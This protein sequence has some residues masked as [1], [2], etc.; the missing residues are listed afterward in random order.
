MSEPSCI[1]E[2]CRVYPLDAAGSRADRICVRDGRIV[3]EISE[4][5]RRTDLGGRTVVPGLTDSHNHLVH[6]GVSVTRAVDLTG[7][8]SVAELQNRLREFRK[9]NPEAPWLLGRR[10]DQEL[11]AEHRWPNRSDLDAVSARVPIMVT[12]LCLHAAVA[13]TAALESVRGELSAEQFETGI[14]TEDAAEA[15]W[16]QIPRPT[17]SELETAA[18]WALGE[19]RKAGLAG[20]HCIVHG[21]DELAV[22][23]KLADAGRLPVRVQVLCPAEWL[24]SLASQGIVTGS[25][26]EWLRVG[27]LK[28]YLDGSMGARTAALKE[29]FSDN[30]STSG[31]LFV[32]ERE[33]A[34]ALVA[35]QR[36]GF[37]AAIHAIG[38]AA[39]ECALEGI[40]L[41]MPDGNRANRLRHR[42]EHAA[43]MNPKLIAKMAALN[44]VASVQPQFITTDFWTWQRV[45]LDRYRWTYPF[46]SMLEA[47][48]VLAMG[49]DC[50][51]ERLHPVELLDRAVNREPRSLHERLNVEQALRAYAHGSAFAGFEENARGSLETGKLADFAVLSE[52]PFH[53]D[54]ACLGELRIEQ[55]VVGGEMQ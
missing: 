41:A 20:V 48:V 11:F 18:V 34:E 8:R 55:N 46:R 7:C 40:E 9:L 38:D 17:E 37:Q 22:L 24:D 25:G 27:A 23:R 3:A 28:L 51:V 5:A 30:P 44:V 12:R 29:P 35:L 15:I 4:G 10:F 13:N 33:L 19:A 54:P 2:N 42:V 39:V 31:Q 45:G 16:R 1:Y 52:D 32:N 50:P 43:Q 6:Y 14:L 26:D 36:G 49:S 21:E 47:G 53:T